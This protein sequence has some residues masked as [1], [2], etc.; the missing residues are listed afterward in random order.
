MKKI[1]K[2]VFSVLI[3]LL[4]FLALRKVFIT[5][6]SL[7]DEFV[8]LILGGLWTVWLVKPFKPPYFLTAFLLFI[9]FTVLHNLVYA[10]FSF[11]EP[12]FFL[13]ALLSLSASVI[14]LIIFVIKKIL[15]SK[16]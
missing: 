15:G 11:E 14:L 4:C 12:V 1:V 5:Q 13:L 16:F 2:L 7:V 6:R 3:Y 8:M 10:I 9:V